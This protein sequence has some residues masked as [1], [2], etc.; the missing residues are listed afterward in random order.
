MNHRIRRVKCDETSPTCK[1]CLDT[2]RMCDGYPSLEQRWEIIT[3]PPPK[4]IRRPCLN[5][6]FPTDATA[7][8]G[9]LFYREHTVYYLSGLFKWELWDEVILR[10]THHSDAIRHAVVGLGSLHETLQ[11]REIGSESPD[12][13][14]A[15]QLK[16]E[17]WALEQYNKAIRS[18]TRI[19]L[20]SERPPIDVVLATCLL[21]CCFE[22]I[23]FQYTVR[24]FADFFLDTSK[25][26]GYSGDPSEKW[27]QDYCGPRGSHAKLQTDDD[28]NDTVQ[29]SHCG[30]QTS[31][32]PIMWI[33]RA[34]SAHSGLP[35]VPCSSRERRPMEGLHFTFQGS[36]GSLGRFEP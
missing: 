1:R 4:S 32:N 24:Q 18:L 10:A 35:P 11:T 22:V 28:R 15:V 34:A 23:K 16:D 9:F 12:Y 13:K 26:F 17:K 3:S 6:M 36:E 2:G 30:F 14:W 27:Y 20:A 33:I 19:D 25:A 29:T 5:I 31:R 7:N 21:F 8:R